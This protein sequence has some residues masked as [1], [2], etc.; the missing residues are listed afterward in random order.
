[1]KKRVTIY[2]IAE[3]AGVSPATVSRMIHQPDI[4]TE[5]T[6]NRIL[7]AFSFHQIRPEDL[8]SRSRSAGFQRKINSPA[9]PAILVCLPSWNNPF[10]DDIL[11]GISDYLEQE[12]SHMIVTRE[13]P[14][15]SAMFSFFNYCASLQIA[16]I[17][18]MYPLSE[19]I[20]RQLHSAYPVVQCSEYNPF[21]TKVPYVSIDDY[22]ISKSAIAHL[23]GAGCKKIA[24]FSSPYDYR[25]VQNRYRAY[26]EMLAGNGMAVRPEYVV[27]VSDFSYPRILAAAQ[28]FF[29]LPDPPDAI[30][31]T[32]DKHAHAAV[33]AGVSMGFSIPED[34]RIFGFDNTMYADLSSPSIS[35][36]EQPRRDLGTQ[37]ARMVLSMIRN[38]S[39]QIKS[40]L[41]PTKLVIRESA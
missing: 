41:L 20:L 6:R 35:T 37:S 22:A 13:I 15:R 23:I 3:T 26:K 24:F 17:I 27:Q 18:M 30:F 14:Q 36:I 5:K 25:Y 4:V 9:A 19:D 8:S 10:Y 12:H 34:I 1:M 31:S 11:E 7:D 40:L 29:R 28:H 21:Y 39:A 32:S 2:D 38:P 33:R 16:G